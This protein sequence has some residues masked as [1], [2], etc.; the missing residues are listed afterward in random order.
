MIKGDATPSPKPN[1]KWV[2]ASRNAEVWDSRVRSQHSALN[3]VEG[4]AEAPGLN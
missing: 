1:P 4:R 2:L 3:E